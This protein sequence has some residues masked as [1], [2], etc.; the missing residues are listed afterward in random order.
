[1]AYGITGTSLSELRFGK[2]YNT[3]SMTSAIY[4]NNFIVSDTVFPP[5][6]RVTEI[7][8]TITTSDWTVADGVATFDTVGDTMTL[9]APA[10]SID[11]ST[12][13]ITGYSPLFLNCGASTNV[14]AI[15]VTQGSTTQQL[16]LPST[17]IETPNVFAVNQLSDIST[18]VIARSVSA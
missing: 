11:E 6:E 10:N 15:D 1:M 13:E 8:P 12:R 18:T 5:T 14:N 2:V 9:T 16:V 17:A 7:T 4:F 3:A